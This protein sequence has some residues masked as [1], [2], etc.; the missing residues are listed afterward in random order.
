[1]IP[2]VTKG[3]VVYAHSKLITLVEGETGRNHLLAVQRT[4]EEFEQRFKK[5]AKEGVERRRGRRICTKLT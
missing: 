5:I 4:C 1:M 2:A 3:G